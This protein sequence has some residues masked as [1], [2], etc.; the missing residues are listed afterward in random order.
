M[1]LL[2]TK[3]LLKPIK[4]FL[5]IDN[6]IR[7]DKR[8]FKVRT[9]SF[10]NL[11]ECYNKMY[12]ANDVPCLLRKKTKFEECLDILRGQR[13]FYGK[14]SAENRKARK[15]QKMMDMTALA[16]AKVEEKVA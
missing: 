1:S 3:Q 9:A 13:E 7:P 5:N 14:R 10:G 16:Q 8:I 11:T 12:Y 2:G 6:E 15:L 4:K